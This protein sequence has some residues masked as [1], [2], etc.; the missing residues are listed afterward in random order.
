MANDVQI[1][2]KIQRN[3]EQRGL[4]VSR[5]DAD[6]LVAESMT[7]TYSA[8]VIQEPMGGVSDSSAP[9]LG[10]G[11]ANPGKIEFDLGGADLNTVEKLQVLRIASGHANNI[12]LSNAA[13]AAVEGELFGH[14]DLLGMGQ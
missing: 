3:C 14:A 8:A 1:L 6:T 2:D 12:V 13:T 10:I 5:T 4:S 11:V 9:Y 7:I